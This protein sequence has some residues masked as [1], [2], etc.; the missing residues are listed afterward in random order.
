MASMEF[1]AKLREA[2][3]RKLQLQ[4]VQPGLVGPI[5]GTVST[6]APTF[7]VAYLAGTPTAL[8]GGLAAPLG[9]AI[10]TAPSDAPDDHRRRH[11]RRRLAAFAA[12]PHLRRA[13]GAERRLRRRRLRAV[14]DRLGAQALPAR[15]A[16]QLAHPGDARRRARGGGGL[17]G[18]SR[19]GALGS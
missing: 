5:D 1:T 2:D 14:R 3:D 9:A 11:V 12:V 17:R 7:A 19:L 13:P 15:V 6:L 4:V 16:G 8:L 18:R 10:G